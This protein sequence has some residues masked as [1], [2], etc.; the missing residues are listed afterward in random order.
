MSLARLA[1][2]LSQLFGG[3]LAPPKP[4]VRYGQPRTAT[5]IKARF[6]IDRGVPPDLRVLSQPLLDFSLSAAAGSSERGHW[7]RADDALSNRLRQ[8]RLKVG[9]RA[10]FPVA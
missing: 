8:H 5:V 7:R 9:E 4:W 2:E 6:V 3:V 10:P 1:K